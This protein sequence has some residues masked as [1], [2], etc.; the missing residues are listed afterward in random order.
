MQPQNNAPVP[1]E[2]PSAVP[3]QPDAQP[4][5]QAS[6]RPLLAFF[7]RAV[8][9][10]VLL[11][12]AWSLVAKWPSYPVAALTHMA[13]EAGAPDWVQTVHKSPGLIE[14]QTRL[15]VPVRGGVGDIVVEA[16]PAHYA[17]SLPI[18]WALLLAAGGP[19][20][21]GK[22]L[23]GYV[24][25]LPTQAFS[26]TLDV[27]KRM[28]IAMPGGVRA[29]GIDQWQLEAIGLGYQLGVLV[30]PTLVPVVVWLW[31]DSAFASRL[32]GDAQLIPTRPALPAKS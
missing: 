7:V 29:L 6:K 19:G 32:L 17:Y 10:L 1:A 30:L 11:M 25:L 27:L 24:L 15:A 31:L 13:L 16:D 3:E 12:G 23:G 5:R 28:A 18:L 8:L 2:R 14:V 9:W 26:L 4:S 20:R 21:I 22:L